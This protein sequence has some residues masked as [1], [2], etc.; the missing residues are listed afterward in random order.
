MVEEHLLI[1][2]N[3]LIVRGCVQVH[4]CRP[5]VPKIF[6]KH[7]GVQTPTGTHIITNICWY[8]C[9]SFVFVIPAHGMPMV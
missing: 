4:F 6:V 9:G 3:Q 8:L 2:L 7:K 1:S 5:H